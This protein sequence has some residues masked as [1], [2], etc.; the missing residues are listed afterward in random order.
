MQAVWRANLVGNALARVVL[1]RSKTTL[2]RNRTMEY[3]KIEAIVE[4][5]KRQ[6]AEYIGNAIRKHPVTTLMVVGLP[7]LLT[8]LP[9][10]SFGVVA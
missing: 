9:W 7:V 2:T 1:F 8:Q 5:A 6:R 3:Q 4:E 10:S